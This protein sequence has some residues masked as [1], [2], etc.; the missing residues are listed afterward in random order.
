MITIFTCLTKN[1]GYLSDIT[2]IKNEDDRYICFYDDD[3]SYDESLG[4]EFI[5]IERDQFPEIFDN[6]R[7]LQQEIKFNPTKYMD[8]SDWYVWLDPRWQLHTNLI[9]NYLKQ[10]ILSTD[11]D[12]VF[13]Y[14]PTRKSFADEITFVY[15]SSKLKRNQ[16]LD[17]ANKLSEL[18][19]N[20]SSFF[21]TLS[22]IYLY[23][24]TDNSKKFSNCITNISKK[25]YDV[26]YYSPRD[27][28]IIP[29]AIDSVDDISYN[30][31]QHTLHDV[32]DDCVCEWRHEP[33][34]LG[35]LPYEELNQWSD[36]IADFLKI[37]QDV[38]E[39]TLKVPCFGI[40]P[41][42]KEEWDALWQPPEM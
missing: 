20:F 17:I 10:T 14:N 11:N 9:F 34:W 12:L 42:T 40:T 1:V 26:D 33:R 24:N 16:C 22:G 8:D 37:V 5:K 36:D 25:I 2:D 4:W 32:L 38:T 3:E 15:T 23:K 28:I 13:F 18:N 35:K 39:S 7:L 29:F 27:Q 31:F 19:V 6:G 21:P 41:E 30:F